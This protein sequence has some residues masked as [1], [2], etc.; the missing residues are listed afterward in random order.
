[1]TS[2]SA[3][4]DEINQQ[5]MDLKYQQ[6][7]SQEQMNELRRLYQEQEVK[8]KEQHRQWYTQLESLRRRLDMEFWIRLEPI[9]MDE[10]RQFE[11]NFYAQALGCG[12]E[13]DWAYNLFRYI[14]EKFDHPAPKLITEPHDDCIYD[15]CDQY[16]WKND[17]EFIFN[18][19][20]ESHIDMGPH[21]DRS[22]RAT[23]HRKAWYKYD[24]GRTTHRYS[25]TRYH[26][27]VTRCKPNVVICVT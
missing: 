23:I 9:G 14:D 21:S 25:G 3:T 5:I 2:P 27:T 1:M 4:I 24:D 10:T 26:V 22:Y 13:S 6:K 17:P 12:P 11:T 16:H 20:L 15:G 18:V 8:C 7:E 19:M